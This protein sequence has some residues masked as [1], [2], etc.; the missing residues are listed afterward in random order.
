ME[1]CPYFSL[2]LWY[3]KSGLDLILMEL[4]SC[5]IL[6]VWLKKPCFCL[7]K[8]T[9]R[10]LKHCF[11]F[12]LEFVKIRQISYSRNRISTCRVGCLI[13]FNSDVVGMSTFWVLCF[14]KHQLLVIYVLCVPEWV[15]GCAEVCGHVR[16]WVYRSVHLGVSTGKNECQLAARV[17]PLEGTVLLEFQQPLPQRPVCPVE[18]AAIPASPTHALGGFWCPLS[19]SR[20]TLT[21]RSSHEPG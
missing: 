10:L 13:I 2:Y 7:L 6:L 4:D 19:L 15:W 14:A 16:A 5:V 1:I 8:Q 3:L 9:F 12:F 17:D 18:G 11:F 21:M 20:A